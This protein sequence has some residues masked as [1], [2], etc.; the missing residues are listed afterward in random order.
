[1]GRYDEAEILTRPPDGRRH[2]SDRNAADER[3]Q[4]ERRAEFDYLPPRAGGGYSQLKYDSVVV[5]LTTIALSS[6]RGLAYVA[7]SAT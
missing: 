4:H 7:L 6:I 1:L 5:S 2:L 3:A